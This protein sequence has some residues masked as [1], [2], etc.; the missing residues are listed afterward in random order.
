[1][2]LAFIYGS[3]LTWQGHTATHDELF[4]AENYVDLI[5]EKLRFQNNR[6]V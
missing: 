6:S 2:L 1:M 4:I 3:R 5:S